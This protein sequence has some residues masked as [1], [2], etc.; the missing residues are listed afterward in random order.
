MRTGFIEYMTEG[1]VNQQKKV[2]KKILNKAKKYLAKQLKT[3]ERH[4][5]FMETWVPGFRDKIFLQFMLLDPNKNT[6]GSTVT[7]ELEDKDK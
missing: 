4:L 3:Q 5:E 7:Y 6:Y 2:D 1:Y